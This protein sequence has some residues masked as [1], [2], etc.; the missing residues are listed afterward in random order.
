MLADGAA[1][2]LYTFAQ[3]TSAVNGREK[4]KANGATD[5]TFQGSHA[6]SRQLPRGEIPPNR[7]G[8]AFVPL[9]FSLEFREQPFHVQGAGN[10]GQSP[11]GGTRPLILLAIAVEFDAVAV[12][13][14]QV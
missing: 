6:K 2:A 3:T 12:V 4:G 7:E 9:P 14:A 8:A 5:L 13:V 1:Q 10:H 11:F